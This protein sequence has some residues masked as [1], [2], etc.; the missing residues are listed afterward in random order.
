MGYSYTTVKTIHARI[1]TCMLH[2]S[3]AQGDK[4]IKPMTAN[5]ILGDADR[6]KITKSQKQID[7]NACMYN[8]TCTCT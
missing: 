6:K 2:C 4:Q 5:H 1:H 3:N 7:M 8:V